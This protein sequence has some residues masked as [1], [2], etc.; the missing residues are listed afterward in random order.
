MDVRIAI[1]RD[2]WNPEFEMVSVDVLVD[3]EPAGRLDAY[4]PRPDLDPDELLL[5]ADSES[6]DLEHI[7]S[8]L[9][10]GTGSDGCGI[11]DMIH[12]EEEQGGTA[13]SNNEFDALMIGL[14]I[15]DR[16]IVMPKY[17]RKGI[18]A[19]LLAE[20]E[21][22][23]CGRLLVA[24]P[25]PLAAKDRTESGKKRL[26][27]WYRSLGWREWS[28]ATTMTYAPRWHSPIR[29]AAKRAARHFHVVDEP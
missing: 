28:G 26:R 2:Q 12:A 8:D 17:R 19:V 24:Y 27:D 14:V 10:F 3:D 18:G 20:L 22:W 29:A 23:M 21:R 4:M 11:A 5:A 1:R 16:I 7:V 6:S 15:V 9:H 25:C 13:Y